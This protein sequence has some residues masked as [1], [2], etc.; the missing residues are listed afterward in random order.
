MEYDPSD[1][2]LSL[3]SLFAG[4]A[5]ADELQRRLADDGFDDARFADGV[6]FQHLVG[7]PVTISTLAE[8]LGVTQ[9]AASK[10][11]A[12]LEHRGYVVRRPDP[13]DARARQVALTERGEAVIST[14]RKHRASLD[15][16]L[17]QALGADEVEQAR[18]LLLAV[19]DHLGATPSLRARAVHPPR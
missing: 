19:V 9:Q 16:D 2:D 5:L 6:V 3:A 7:G 4:W 1:A 15:A 17:R 8:K 13:V 14:A 12:D 18:R 11:V 10:S